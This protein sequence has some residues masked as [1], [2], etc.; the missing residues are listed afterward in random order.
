MANTHNEKLIIL[1]Q[2]HPKLYDH[3][4]KSYCYIAR[5]VD[6]SQAISTSVGCNTGYIK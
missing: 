5:K 1:V 3:Q 2:Q 6:I 4:L